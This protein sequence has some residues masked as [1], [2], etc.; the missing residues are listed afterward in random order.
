MDRTVPRIRRRT[1]TV[2]ALLAA[3]LLRALIPAGFMPAVGAG[4]LALVFCAPGM[5]A[6]AGAHAHQ[7]HHGQHGT[8]GTGHSAA[9]QCPFA[10]SAAPALPTVAA[11][12][13]AP[14]RLASLA[15]TRR[16]DQVAPAVTPRHA[17]ARG[18]PTLC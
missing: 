6:G 3:L 1:A 17:A 13:Y 5:A 12:H 15:P 9:A 14:P 10:Q 8:G 7:H 4:S 16:E 2:T 11:L 18:P